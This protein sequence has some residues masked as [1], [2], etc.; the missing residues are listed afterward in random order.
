MGPAPRFTVE[1]GSSPALKPDRRPPPSVLP[2]AIAPAL[3]V[4]RLPDR[5]VSLA[6]RPRLSLRLN[7]AEIARKL[8]LPPATFSLWLVRANMGRMA[9]LDPPEPLRRCQ[10]ARH[11]N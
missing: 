6:L 9:Q 3:V 7:G 4:G 10:L 1:S 2:C 8:G 11:G 5:L